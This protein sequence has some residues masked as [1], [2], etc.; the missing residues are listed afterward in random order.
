[1]MVSMVMS[2]TCTLSSSEL[3]VEGCPVFLLGVQQLMSRDVYVQWMVH[4]SQVV[5]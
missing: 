2:Y 1:M 5:M 3:E 4:V